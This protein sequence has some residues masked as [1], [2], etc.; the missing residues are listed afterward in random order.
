MKLRKP[1]PYVH[2]IK[3]RHGTPR[4][5]LRKPGCPSVALPLPI[6]CRAFLEAYQAALEEAP[7]IIGRSQAGSIAALVQLYLGS[8]LWKELSP[9]SQRTYRHILDHFVAGHGHRLVAQM[10]AKHVAKIIADKAESRPPPTSCAS[11]YRCSCAWP[12]WK[13]GERT[14]RSSRSRA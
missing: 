5:Y 10:E 12:S 7:K 4:A 13:V 9:Q 8:Q 11:S 2:E 14:I 6:G 3:D 1:Y